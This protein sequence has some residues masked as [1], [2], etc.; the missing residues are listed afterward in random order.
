MTTIIQLLLV[1]CL[2]TITIQDIKDRLVWWFLFP[3]FIFCSGFLHFSRSL[4]EI[5]IINL[6]LNYLIL[7]FIFFI[8]FLYARFK[9]KLNF[10]RDTFGIGDLLFF[11]GLATAFP[12]L[13]F[14]VIFVA[15]L[16]FSLLLHLILSRKKTVETVPL[17]GYAAFFL[18]LI[19]LS[20]WTNVYQN[21]YSY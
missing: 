4:E 16:V 18:L 20:D 3:V 7:A 10:F 14:T 19:F 13:S 6:S 15:V 2:L 9:M 8:C 1:V 21:L 17:A 12:T 5:F 11:I